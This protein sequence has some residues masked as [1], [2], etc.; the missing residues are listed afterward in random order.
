MQMNIDG[1]KEF[2]GGDWVK[3]DARIRA[4]LKSD[5]ALLDSTNEMILS[6]SGKQLRPLLSLL[7]A[8]ACSG[9]SVLPEDSIRVAAAAELLHNA[10]LLHDDV[11]DESDCRRGFPTLNSLMGPSV[12]VLVGDKCCSC[13]KHRAGIHAKLTI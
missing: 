3:V 7:V 5:I 9:D 4:A 11:A 12:S 6:H 1:L 10:T 8:K 2:C 13:R